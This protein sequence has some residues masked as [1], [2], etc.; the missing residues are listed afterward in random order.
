MTD[1]EKH[2][3][4]AGASRRARR[5]KALAPLLALA[6]AACAWPGQAAEQPEA[7]PSAP[8]SATPSA[9]PS[10]APTPSDPTPRASATTPAEASAPPE[11]SPPPADASAPPAE[12][13]ATEAPP[14]EPTPTPTP[15]DPPAPSYPQRGSSGPEVL[16]LQQRLQELGYGFVKADG[17]YGSGTQ[18]AVWAFQK[19]AGLRRDGVVGPKTQQ[20]L[21]EGFRSQARSSSGKVVEIDID[22][23]ILLAV[24]DGHVVRIINASSGNG[25]TFEAKGRSYRAVTNRGTFKVTSQENGMHASTLELGDMWRPKYFNGAI[26]VHGSGSIPP[27]P[28]SHGC[29]RVSNG[30]MNWLWD[31]WGMPIG[32]PVLVY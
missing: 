11:A 28:A 29:V 4:G 14:A 21:D 2:S 16:A 25:K 20:L 6:L 7:G 12:A 26:A 15:T 8:A 1:R 19:A 30:A 18:Q 22:R 31:T 9:T 24:E 13:P 3:K 32:T 5:G 23:Q 10:P 27:Y 17:D